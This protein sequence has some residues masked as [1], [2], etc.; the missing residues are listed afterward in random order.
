M[1]P[2]L[3]ARLPLSAAAQDVPV[4][5]SPESFLALLRA[6]QVAALPAAVAVTQEVGVVSLAPATTNDSAWFAPVGTG[7]A[8]AFEDAATRDTVLTNL[9]TGGAARTY[10]YDLA[11]NRYLFQ[12]RELTLNATYSAPMKNLPMTTLNA[13]NNLMFLFTTEFV[14]AF[15]SGTEKSKNTIR[16]HL[17]KVGFSSMLSPTCLP[18]FFGRS[19]TWQPN[20]SLQCRGMPCKRMGNKKGFGESRSLLQKLFPL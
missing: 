6:E 3:M 20:C 19:A 17:S 12:G 13:D 2:V 11:G 8:P 15:K 5:D 10:A 18:N 16:V 1:V 9:A 4:I 14:H 7:P